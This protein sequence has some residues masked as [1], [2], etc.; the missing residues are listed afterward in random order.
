[1][2]PVA[3]VRQDIE[4]AESHHDVSNRNSEQGEHG[5]N[6][7]KFVFSFKSHTC[8]EMILNFLWFIV[9]G[10]HG[11]RLKRRLHNDAGSAMSDV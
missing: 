8:F 3:R 5:G 4:A 1:M 10:K 6:N 2:D 11:I 9:T 7:G